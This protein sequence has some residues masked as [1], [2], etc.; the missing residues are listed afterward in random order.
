MICDNCK[1]KEMCKY[2]GYMEHLDAH[3]KDIP[4]NKDAKININITC[5]YMQTR[6][7]TIEEKSSLDDAFRS[8]C[9]QQEK[10]RLGNAE[11][12]ITNTFK[13]PTYQ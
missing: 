3:V 12:L 4:L 2:V 7:R 13:Y 11:D 1:N 10:N 8:L 9:N 6:D 5:G